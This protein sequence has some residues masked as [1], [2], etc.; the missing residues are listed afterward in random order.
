MKGFPKTAALLM[1]L[2]FLGTGC[3]KLDPNDPNS[4]TGIVNTWWGEWAGGGRC[5]PYKHAILPCMQ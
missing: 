2:A 4:E 1:V 5:V 3:C